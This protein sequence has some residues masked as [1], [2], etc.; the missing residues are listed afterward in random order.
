VAADQATLSPGG[1]AAVSFSPATLPDLPRSL[2]DPSLVDLV[3]RHEELSLGAKTIIVYVLVQPRRRVI[4]R[5]EL[6][7]LG[8]DAVRGQLDGLLHEL[9]AAHWLMPVPGEER[10]CCANGFLLREDAEA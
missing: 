2:S 6:E 8:G 7:R 4:T 1:D 5:A 10:P 3:L 9:V